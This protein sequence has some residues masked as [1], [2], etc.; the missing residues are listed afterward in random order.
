[1]EKKEIPSIEVVYG[2]IGSIQISNFTCS[3]L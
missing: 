3:S 1:M 2:V